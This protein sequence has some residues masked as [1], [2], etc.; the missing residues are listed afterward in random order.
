MIGSLGAIKTAT[1][2]APELGPL[3]HTSYF[4]CDLRGGPYN[5]EFTFIGSTLGKALRIA[6]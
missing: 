4:H 6:S 2:V 1:L 3:S 5:N